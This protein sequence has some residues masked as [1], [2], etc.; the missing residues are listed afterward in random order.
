MT[1][2]ITDIPAYIFGAREVRKSLVKL[3]LVETELA[4]FQKYSIIFEAK[5]RQHFVLM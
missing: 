5:K 3:P 4:E 1:Y 2:S